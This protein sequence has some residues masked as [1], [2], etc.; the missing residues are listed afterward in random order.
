MPQAYAEMYRHSEGVP[1]RLNALASRVML[2]GA[3]EQLAVIDGADVAA[4]ITD[5]EGDTPT[6]SLRRPVAASGGAAVPSR[7]AA[8]VDESLSARIALLET[9]LEEQETAI[10]RVLT[11][12][13]D[14]AE[15]DRQT[16]DLSLIRET[17]A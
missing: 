8:A 6:E 17:A 15:T 9:R 16:P 10:R 3:V 13:I 11:L 4:V 14:W 12:L 1:R 2:F 7:A 5:M